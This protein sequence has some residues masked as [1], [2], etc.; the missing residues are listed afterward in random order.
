ME[1]GGVPKGSIGPKG[2]QK[3]LERDL[4]QDLEDNKNN[5]NKIMGGKKLETKK[6]GAQQ[7]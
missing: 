4:E 1:L 2:F 3:V 7:N 6:T 5:N